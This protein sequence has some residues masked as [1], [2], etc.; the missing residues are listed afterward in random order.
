MGVVA[1]FSAA[2]NAILGYHDAARFNRG[3]LRDEAAIRAACAA[4]MAEFDV[5]PPQPE[6]RLAAFSGG[7]QQKLS[8]DLEIDAFHFLDLDEVGID[9]ARK[10]DLVEVNLLAQNEVKQ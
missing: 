3:G 8:R 5:R 4:K 6:L 9:D 7:N 2:D 1:G 10:R